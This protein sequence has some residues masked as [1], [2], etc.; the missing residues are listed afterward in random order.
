MATRSRYRWI[1]KSARGTLRGARAVSRMSRRAGRAQGRR[2]GGRMKRRFGMVPFLAGIGLGAGAV[3]LL[4]PA[5]G[6]RRRHMLRDMTASKLRRGSRSAEKGARDLAGRAQGVVADAT[7]P[8]RDSSELN[9]PALEAKVESELFRPAAA[10]KG[11]VDVSVENGV[12]FLRGEV[13]DRKSLESMVAEA[14]AID[15]VS[16]IES[17]LHVPGEPAPTKE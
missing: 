12:V 10:P 9:D 8:G 7:P 3:Y 4:D 17:L 14:H 6:R 5:E 1:A 15:G 11:S 13:P 2:E 16:R